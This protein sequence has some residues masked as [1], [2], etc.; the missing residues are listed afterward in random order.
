MIC[1]LDAVP[2]SLFNVSR[3]SIAFR[4]KGVAALSRPSMLALKFITIS[5]IA[6]CCSGI[7]GN[8]RL[9]KGFSK[10]ASQRTAPAFSAIFI[11]PRKKII[12]PASGNPTLIT[13]SLAAVNKPSTMVLKMS[14]LPNTSHFIMATRNPV[15]KKKIQ[16]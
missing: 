15:T 8:N 11:R 9:S 12:V 16:T 1:A 6:G 4:P 14:V 3:L 5:P 2:G 10:R 13:E 7:S